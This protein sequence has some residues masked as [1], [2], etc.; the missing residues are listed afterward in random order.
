MALKLVVEW[1][2]ASLRVAV[3][4]SRG[5][6]WR[7]RAIHSQALAPA[8]DPGDVL[9]GMLKQAGK[10]A[11]APVISVISREQVI[12]RLVRFPATAAAEVAQMAELYAKGQLPYAREQTVM[13]Y[14]VLQQQEGF[15]TVAIVACQREVVDRQLATLRAAGCNAGQVT[16]SSWGVLGWY[17][18]L[19][20][21]GVAGACLVVNVDDTRTDLVLIGEGRILT[22]RSI[23]QGVHDWQASG[24][25]PAELL[26]AEIERSRA[27]VRKELPGTEVQAVQ[28]TGLGELPLW[29][30]ALT[31]R[32]GVPVSVTAPEAAWK[33]TM[34]RLHTPISPVVVGG[35]AGMTG[36]KLLNLSPAE[37]QGQ[38][39]HRRQVQQLVLVG[40]LVLMVLGLGAAALSLQVARQQQTIQ[41]LEQVTA[42]AAPTARQLQQ[43][44]RA[45]QTV[46]GLLREREQVVALL[47][48]VLQQ[49][50]ESIT[51]EG[52]AFERLRRELVLRG[53]APSTQAVLDYL[54]RLEQVAGIGGVEL[55]F[56]TTRVEVAGE[57]VDFEAVVRQ[58][59]AG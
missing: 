36:E 46:G 6:K 17:Q 18:Q 19:S 23:G 34:L 4:E 48:T 16:V 15:S 11:G 21:A 2:R 3:A 35:L 5:A 43:K 52:L 32:L 31:Q 57:H 49:T 38:A 37:V 41:Q 40:V 42:Q 26:G 56:S 20:A 47:A 55:K 28:L 10:V 58:A 8:V 22:S 44:Q 1:T 51:L 59:A 50:P 9:R 45:A 29:K 53:R 33:E 54:G 24:S 25:D 30:V 12:T 27:S 7:V 14:Y 13:D 39:V